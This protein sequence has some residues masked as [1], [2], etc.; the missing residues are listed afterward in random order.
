MDELTLLRHI[1][2]AAQT[3]RERQREYFRT[4]DSR[5]L[6]LS[7]SAESHLDGMLKQYKDGRYNEQQSFLDSS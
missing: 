2:G 6:Y 4:R 3:V 5:I 1:A 7:K